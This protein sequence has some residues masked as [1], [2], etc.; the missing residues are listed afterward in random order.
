MTRD[1]RW[2]VGGT[3]GHHAAAGGRHRAGD[4]RGRAAPAAAVRDHGAPDRAAA[5]SSSACPAGGSDTISWLAREFN[6]MADSVTGLVGEVRDQRERLETVINSIDDGIVV[7]DAAAARDRRQ[8]RV[9]ACG[10]GTRARRC[11]AASAAS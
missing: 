5:T 9:P 6:T 3:G 7:L 10:R 2:M 4:P 1:L 11:W 8:R